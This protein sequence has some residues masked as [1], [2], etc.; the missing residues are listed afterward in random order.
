MAS[1]KA[2]ICVFNTFMGK[3]LTLD[4]NHLLLDAE[5]GRPL[6]IRGETL[7]K[8]NQS[9][10]QGQEISE[11][12]LLKWIDRLYDFLES[13]D[14]MRHR[15]SDLAFPY[16]DG[17]G[18]IK[19]LPNFKVETVIPR[20]TM[21]VVT[22]GV[23]PEALY[24]VRTRLLRIGLSMDQV[25]AMPELDLCAY[26]LKPVRKGQT[27]GTLPEDKDKSVRKLKRKDEE[28]IFKELALSGQA[29]KGRV[30]D[31]GS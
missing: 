18:N 24:W 22:E 31:L 11:G 9:R 26:A 30:L 16:K 4:L 15:K 17:R 23:D 12:T 21:N 27:V 8:V 13:D 5:E 19:Y 28:K 3:R 1:A 7:W 20:N 25:P 14:G 2:V 6:N 10:F 29:M